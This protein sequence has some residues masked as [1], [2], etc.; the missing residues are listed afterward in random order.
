[1]SQPAAGPRRNT[2]SQAR[3]FQGSDSGANAGRTAGSGVR[4]G[5][6][7][8]GRGV[9]EGRRPSGPGQGARAQARGDRADRR[10][11]RAGAQAG[12]HLRERAQGRRR[13]GQGAQ[14]LG[15]IR[16][17]RRGA[18][19][20]TGRAFDRDAELDRS[21]RRFRRS[22]R[23]GERA[24]ET[25]PGDRV[26][27]GDRIPQARRR[28]RCLEAAGAAGAAGRT[29]CRGRHPQAG[30]RHRAR[31]DAGRT[32]RGLRPG[33]ERGTGPA[34]RVLEQGGSGLRRVS[35]RSQ[36]GARSQ[37][38][39][40]RNRPRQPGLPGSSGSSCGPG[41]GLGS[42]RAGLQSPVAQGRELRGEGR[43][44]DALCRYPGPGGSGDLGSA[45]SHPA[46]VRARSRGRAVAGE[47]RGSGGSRQPLR[48]AAAGLRPPSRSKRGPGRAGRVAVARG[49]A[50]RRGAQ[51]SGTYQ[52]L[53]QTG[54][55]IDRGVV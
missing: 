34:R 7:S 19:A 24:R 13:G 44:V 15:R 33:A 27:R 45:G 10:A 3:S 54:A 32:L 2:T 17:S 25:L 21:A 52:Y 5:C 18:E 38:A 31:G 12:R 39:D 42:A 55:G 43:A 37:P 35:R 28:G 36:A 46:G 11:H 1:M 8:A 14:G 50:I 47:S 26:S 29:V 48:G 9:R 40:V 53:Y 51:G 20:E 30:A 16:S 23:A 22:G 41:Q 49:Q 4:A 6:R